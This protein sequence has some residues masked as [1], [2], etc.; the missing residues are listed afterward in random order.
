MEKHHIYEWRKLKGLSQSELGRRVGVTLTTIRF[1][2]QNPDHI[3][4]RYVPLI[5]E[6]LNVEQDNILFLPLSATSSSE[7]K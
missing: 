4:I 2:E 1:W 3:Q 7:N 5:A 6:A